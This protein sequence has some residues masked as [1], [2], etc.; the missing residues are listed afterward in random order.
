[1]Q[2]RVGRY[3]KSHDLISHLLS[4]LTVTLFSAEEGDSSGTWK[5]LLDVTASFPH[6]IPMAG[7]P[8]ARGFLPGL[9]TIFY[10]VGK[11]QLA[12]T[13][14]QDSSNHC[15]S[16]D[17]GTESVLMAM[18]FFS[19]VGKNYSWNYRHGF[20]WLLCLL[21]LLSFTLNNSIVP[22][23][24]LYLHHDCPIWFLGLPSP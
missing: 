20:P 10:K 3:S 24:S 21:F 14:G 22:N 9:H 15:C 8:R 4:S 11:L 16:R 17:G 19:G 5:R 7:G 23:V 13:W 2:W 1:M 12:M 18:M 6:T